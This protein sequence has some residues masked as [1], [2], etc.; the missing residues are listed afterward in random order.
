[1]RKLLNIDLAKKFGVL[2]KEEEGFYRAYVNN[3]E[4]KLVAEYKTLKSLKNK[5][6]LWRIEDKTNVANDE[7]R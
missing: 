2:I 3:A 4:E 6:R 1:M 7:G 5:L